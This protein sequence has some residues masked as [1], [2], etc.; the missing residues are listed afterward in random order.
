MSA[1][2][3]SSSRHRQSAAG[4]SWREIAGE[5]RGTAESDWV[6]RR[7]EGLISARL[8]VIS[9]DLAH[10]AMKWRCVGAGR[11]T[12]AS[13]RSV[14]VA[15]SQLAAREGA[16]L[17]EGGGNPLLRLRRVERRDEARDLAAVQE[18]VQLP[19]LVARGHGREPSPEREVQRQP[20]IGRARPREYTIQRG[21][22]R[23]SA[24]PS[25]H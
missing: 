25:T 14:V 12:A 24:R 1:R 6:L 3:L 23:S 17:T 4:V 2:P 21:A 10:G 11:L 16:P 19:R 5:N 15:C 9:A 13:S 22:H 8:G 18:A 20:G 7:A